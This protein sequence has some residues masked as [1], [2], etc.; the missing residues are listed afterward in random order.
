MKKLARRMRANLMNIYSLKACVG[1]FVREYSVL[2]LSIEAHAL[3]H[4]ARKRSADERLPLSESGN[5]RSYR[6]HPCF[7]IRQR[8]SLCQL[9]GHK[10]VLFSRFTVTAELC[11]IITGWVSVSRSS[12]CASIAI[13]RGAAHIQVDLRLRLI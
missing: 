3:G 12:R 4:F 8:G 11:S 2:G 10:P 9:N 5:S 1:I 6:L 7:P 13:A